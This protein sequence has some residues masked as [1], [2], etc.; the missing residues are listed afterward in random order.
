MDDYRQSMR[1]VGIVL[2]VVGI[3]DIG[4][5]AWCIAHQQNY[6]S[7]FNIFA[8][9]AGILLIRGSLRTANVVAFFSAFMLSAFVGG[10]VL[11]PLLVPLDLQFTQLRLEPVSFGL[12]TLFFM[13]V[14][15]LLGWIY[16]RLTAPPIVAAIAERYPSFTRSWRRPRTGFYVGG[17]LAVTLGIAIPLM[18]HGETA[19]R[20]IAEA[21]Q[22]VGD[23]YK[24]HVSS[25][26]G[27]SSGGRSHYAAVV[28]AYNQNEIR[29]I[30]VEWDE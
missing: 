2:T 10:L 17:I 6:S 8:V 12:S 27:G 1:V 30:P 22:K 15:F 18:M 26:R 24:F 11:S 7:S 20:A 4:W 29:E 13:C 23:H 3:L 16:R 14:L 9:V 19:D 28:T 25:W 21:R 5:M